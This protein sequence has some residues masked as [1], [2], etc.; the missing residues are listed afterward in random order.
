MVLK[1]INTF[2]SQAVVESLIRGCV[3]RFEAGDYAHENP[4]LVVGS[5]GKTAPKAKETQQYLP[6]KL[7]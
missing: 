4:E 1:V 2:P 5:C 7:P 3:D 6:C